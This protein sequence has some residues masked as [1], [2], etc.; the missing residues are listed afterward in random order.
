MT[1]LWEKGRKRCCSLQMASE[2]CCFLGS[3]V[4]RQD[5]LL[6]IRVDKGR[7]CERGGKAF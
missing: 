4:Y 3:R 2:T 5:W 1:Y 6:L 7:F